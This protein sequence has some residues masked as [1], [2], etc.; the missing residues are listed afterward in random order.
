MDN[1]AMDKLRKL[2]TS[3]DALTT[4]AL[5][6]GT[7]I[8]A[9]LTIWL[10]SRVVGFD[11][12]GA[13]AQALRAA[14]NSPWGL[15]VAIAVFIGGSFIGAPQFLLIALSVAAFGPLKGFV[16]AHLST[17]ISASVNFLIARYVGAGFVR[18]RQGPTLK[19]LVEAIGRNGFISAIVVR[20]IPSAPFIVVNMALG[21][22]TV[23]YPAFLAGTAI[24]IIPKTALIA[25]LGKVVQRA[26]A[27]DLDAIFYLVLAAVAWIGVA[28][29]T[30][31]LL[32]RRRAASRPA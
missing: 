17:L 22:T 5:V 9:S 16:F 32:Q 11:E 10:M 23:S 7:I 4:T 12:D 14:A 8:A 26:R 13:L 27:G 28:L 24:G 19:S 6:L 20:I 29:L 25:L 15:I 31:W 2:L 18:R 21:L 3:R 30:R 1:R